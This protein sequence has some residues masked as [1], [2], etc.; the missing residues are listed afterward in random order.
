[1]M[2]TTEDTLALA[3]LLLDDDRC[4]DSWP[5]VEKLRDHISRRGRATTHERRSLLSIQQGLDE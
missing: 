4:E 1:M 2:G 3:D 5:F